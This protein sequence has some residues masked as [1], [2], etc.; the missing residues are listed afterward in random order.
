MRSITEAKD[1]KG[2]K[3]LLR[4]DLNMPVKD[5]VVTNTFRLDQSLDTINFLKD[6]GSKVILI[7]HIEN[8]EGST[9]EVV[10]PELKKHLNIKFCKDIFSEE[11]K[12]LVDGLKDG[13]FLLFENLRNW[14]GEKSNDDIFIKKLSSYADVYIN[15]A[16]SVSHREHASVVGLPKYL[17]SYC[18]IRFAKEI[19][20]LSKVFSPTHPFVFILGGAK[21]ET[22]IPLIEKFLDK[23]DKVIVGGALANDIYKARGFEVGESLVSSIDVGEYADNYKIEVPEEIV[24]KDKV[25]KNINTVIADDVILDAHPDGLLAFE[26]SINNASLIVWNGPLG[27]YEHGYTEGTETLARMIANSSATSVV[28]GGDTLAAIENLGINNSIT[29]I[30]TGGGAM[31]D[32]LTN[33]TLPGIEA[34][35]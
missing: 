29:F 19:D 14:D 25:L 12:V 28:G 18:G 26:D 15:E 35:K 8:K 31:L 6:S 5:G 17:D 23:A 24:V 33:E 30:S 9:L 21:F 34:L 4:L 10:L 3:V 27:D 2:K 32:F 7:S 1:L 13:E 11:T 20:E 22:K 16:F